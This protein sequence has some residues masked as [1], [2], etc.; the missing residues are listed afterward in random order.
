LTD[1]DERVLDFSGLQEQMQKLEALADGYAEFGVKRDAQ[2]FLRAFE[3]QM[4]K[5]RALADEFGVERDGQPGWGFL[6]AYQ[7]ALKHVPGFSS[8]PPRRGRGRPKEK[9][10]Q[11]RLCL[12]EALA[13]YEA[14]GPKRGAAARLAR[15][16]AEFTVREKRQG[17][18]PN[19][20]Q[21]DT[22]ARRY[23][24]DLSKLSA[25]ERVFGR[26]IAE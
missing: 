6:L 19:S 24:N 23:E 14:R 13:L 12:A 10:L 1:D 20:A 15:E 2:D 3:E 17:R 25:R 4:Q 18:R 9:T 7:L 11:Y 26:K 21:V 22:A 5:L 16:L 8:P